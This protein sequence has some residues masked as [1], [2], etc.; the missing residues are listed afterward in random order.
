[1]AVLRPTTS[2]STVDQDCTK[3]PCKNMCFWDSAAMAADTGAQ[4]QAAVGFH[5]VRPIILPVHVLRTI[6]VHL[7]TCLLH[8]QT[9]SMP[10]KD[11]GRGQLPSAQFGA[12]KRLMHHQ[13]ASLALTSSTEGKWMGPMKSLKSPQ[14][15]SQRT[16]DEA[17]SLQHQLV[18]GTHSSARQ[19]QSF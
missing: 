19:I 4:R 12:R 5:I 10:S 11:S 2:Q 18:T 8:Q 1:M 13:V 14:L 9:V 16:D 15:W 3:T 6:E 17:S 7:N